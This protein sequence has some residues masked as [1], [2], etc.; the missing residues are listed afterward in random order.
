M[1]KCLVTGGAGFIGSHLVEKLLKLGKKVRVLDNFST[2]HKDN[3]EPFQDRVDFIEGDIRDRQIVSVAMKNVDY[4]FHLAANCAVPQSMEDPL[5][6]HEVNVTGTLNLLLA[7]RDEKAKRFVFSSS[8]AVYGDTK[9]FPTREENPLR[10]LSP[11]GSSKVLG[12][13]YNRLFSQA[14][15]LD[16][17]SLRYFNVYGPRQNPESRY[18]TVIP[19][20]VRSF[21]QGKNPKIHWDG[22]QSRDFVYVDDVV[23][24]NLLAIEG[25]RQNASVYNIASGEEL[26]ILEIYTMLAH[27]LN[28]AGL[29]P[30]FGP[31]RPG[32]VRRALANIE[33]AK[34][35][36]GY[37]AT[38]PFKRGIKKT[39]NWFIKRE[40]VFGRETY[41]V[42]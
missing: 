13:A 35:K 39:L 42:E 11:Y 17:V 24:A 25:D 12:E 2:G 28:R 38:V 22:K 8:A 21:L 33:K 10:P 23:R 9:K 7:A 18:S 40:G 1:D 5:E 14:Y 32:D 20:F 19:I 15:G 31:K 34:K 36:L 37:R 30:S 4:V 41:V 29:K 27:E 26:S 3:L 6:T 16:T